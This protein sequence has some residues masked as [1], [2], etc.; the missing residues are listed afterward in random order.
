MAQRILEHMNPDFL[1]LGGEPDTEAALT[2][3]TALNDPNVYAGSIAS[4]IDGL[5]RRTTVIGAGVG[6][7]SPLAFAER[8]ADVDALDAITIHIYPIW[9][10]PI[11]NATLISAIARAKG[12]R[13]T[14]DEA[15]LYKAATAEAT[16]VAAN[17]RVFRR[18]PFDFWAPLDNKFL[19]V[20]ARLA[21]V[22]GID[23]VSPFWTTYFFGMLRWEPAL[24]DLPY[25]VLVQRV[26]ERAVENLVAGRLSPVGEHYKSIISASRLQ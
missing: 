6:T 3:L 5:D 1:G 12:K 16:D 26:N 17:E 14:L 24:E 10:A 9:K 4:I 8:L 20:I 22:E 11:E 2:G 15:W 25:S 7:W 19:S 23:F 13:I 21:E 18:D